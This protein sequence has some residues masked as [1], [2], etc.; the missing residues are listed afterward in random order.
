MLT[1]AN[2]PS[3]ENDD[4]VCAVVSGA[5]IGILSL[6]ISIIIV[7]FVIMRLY[8]RKKSRRAHDIDGEDIITIKPNPQQ[9]AHSTAGQ[10]QCDHTES[11]RLS[12]GAK[13]DPLSRLQTVNVLYIQTEVKSLDSLL[14]CDHDASRVDTSDCDVIITPN[15]SYTASQLQAIKKSDQQ[16]DYIRI[17]QQNSLVGSTTSG[18][19]H[20]IVTDP[21]DNVNIDTNPSYSLPQGNQNVK[22]EDNPS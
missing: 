14:K 15:P 19:I 5:V 13:V 10:S 7:L 4:S 2:A 3:S 22:L 1:I 12:Q 16:Y 11:D 21:A 6:I 8:R 18:G 9:Y 17:D 20:N